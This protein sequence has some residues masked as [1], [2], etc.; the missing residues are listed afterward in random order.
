MIIGAIVGGIIIFA[1]QTLSYTIL[2]LHEKS[3]QYTPKQD[4]ILQ[5]LDSQDLEPG[6]YMIPRAPNDVSMEEA[7]KQFEPYLGK[8]WA[9][10]TYY[11]DLDMSM[12]MNM[13]RGLLSNMIMVFLLCWVFSKIPNA[14][15][16]TYF[17]GTVFVGLIAFINEPYTGHIWYPL[18]DIGA[19]LID[20]L[21][22]WGLCGIWL[23]WW[24]AR[25]K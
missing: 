23:G 22:A 8:P 3:M 13:I 4:A 17:T 16:A 12:G 21:A 19:F 1:W 2:N 24:L 14:S 9:M 15:Y 10:V 20:S 11:D 25:K 6:G 18:Y 7:Q 5:F